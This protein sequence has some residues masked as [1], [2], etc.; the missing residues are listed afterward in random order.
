MEIALEL[1]RW[2]RQVAAPRSGTSD[3]CSQLVILY[4]DSGDYRQSDCPQRQSIYIPGASRFLI[5]ISAY[6]LMTF[7]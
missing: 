3:W 5:T 4:T 7:I 2:I 1:F 6:V